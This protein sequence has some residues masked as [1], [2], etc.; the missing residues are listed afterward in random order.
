M[1]ITVSGLIGSGKSTVARILAEKT[2]Y[3]YI[4]GGDMFRKKASERSMSVEQ[5]SRFA[6]EHPE[7]DREQD[8]VLLELL[9]DRDEIILDSRLSGWLAYRNSIEAFKIF[10]LADLDERCRRVAKRESLTPESVKP[11][12]LERENSERKRYREFYSIDI[13]NT[14]IYDAVMEADSLTAMEVAERAYGKFLQKA[15]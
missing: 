15:D 5:Y 7:V 14:G 9:R 12:V 2:G 4:S 10:L 3:E 1:K 8:Q 11:L 6:E 13:D